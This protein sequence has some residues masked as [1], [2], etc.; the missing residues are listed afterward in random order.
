MS[1]PT[2]SRPQLGFIRKYPVDLALVSLIAALVALVVTG[3]P[4]GNAGRLLVAFPLV[5]FLPG[6]A[7]VSV[8]F[9]AA[10]RD[11]RDD[12][13]TAIERRPRGIDT[14][15]RLGL[16][17]ALSI[18]I[19][20]VVGIVLPLT[21]WGLATE[22]AAAVLAGLT[23]VLAQLGVIRRLRTPARDRFT[24]S[25]TAALTGL[26][27]D[28]GTVATASSV[29]LVVAIAVAGG[30]LLAGFLFP[31]STGGFS[32]LALYTEDEDGD[33]VAGELPDEVAPGESVPVSFAIENHEGEE[34]SYTVV[35][36]EQVLEDGEVV[37]RTELGQ[38]DGTV[39][40]DTTGVA[41]REITPAAGDGET[42]RISLL[43]YPGEP[44]AEPTNENAEADT[45][46]WVTVTEDAAE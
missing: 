21:E 45:Y 30:A 32:E 10:A 39:S 13:E 29:L 34:T 26:R 16:S 38:I 36:Q 19:V 20:P 44:P 7:L 1:F 33:L 8:L 14:V 18:A 9:P 6:Y 22:S 3:V 2:N 37:E 27:R 46:F 43:L 17:F 5:L 24:V 11:G 40:A 42:V 28:E 15:E 12:A 41:E 4:A 23:V 25:L 31:A 35:V